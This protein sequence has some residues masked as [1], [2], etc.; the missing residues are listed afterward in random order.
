M[1]HLGFA[2]VF[3]LVVMA[4]IYSF[5]DVSGAHIKPAV[6]IGFWASGRFPLRQVGPY[7]AAQLLGAIAAGF[8]LR[9]IFPNGGSLGSTVPSG[10]VVQSL[11]LEAI[12]TWLLMMVILHVSTGAKEKGIMAGAAIGS[13]VGLAALF[14]GPVSGASLNPARSLGPALASGTLDHLWIYLVAP[15]MGAVIAIPACRSIA[16]PSCCASPEDG[17][18]A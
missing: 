2:G 8:A 5:G 6:T 3:G 18:C 15:V 1:T 10:A 13:V 9:A 17:G 14:G 16:D 7:V 12:L 11:V 4:M